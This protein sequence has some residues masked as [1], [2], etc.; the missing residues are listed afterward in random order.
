[1]AAIGPDR[2]GAYVVMY[3]M[4]GTVNLA[5]RNDCRNKHAKIG[6]FLTSARGDSIG[7]VAKF[8]TP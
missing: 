4:L 6:S 8:P 3:V 2:S 7:R 1:M 5:L